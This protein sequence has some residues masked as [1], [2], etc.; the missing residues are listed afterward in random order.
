[1][2]STRAQARALRSYLGCGI[3]SLEELPGDDKSRDAGTI[4]DD[5]PHAAPAPPAP[6]KPSSNWSE[7]QEKAAQWAVKV[8]AFATLLEATRAAYT[9]KTRDEFVI[10]C[11]TRTRA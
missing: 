7:N 3:T 5:G 8:G 11:R 1:M 2:A 6:A 10:M 9:C 4:N